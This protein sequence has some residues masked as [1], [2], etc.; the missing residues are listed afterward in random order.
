MSNQSTIDMNDN[1]LFYGIG[2]ALLFVASTAVGNMPA[3]AL[4]TYV[5]IMY[6][7]QICMGL[8]G[9]GILSGIFTLYRY[10]QRKESPWRVPQ[11]AVFLPYLVFFFSFLFAILMTR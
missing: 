11:S 3:L 10:N 9:L 2:I 7:L 5:S 1:T 4:S 8:Y 6:Q